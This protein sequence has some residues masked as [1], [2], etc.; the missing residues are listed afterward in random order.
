MNSS[1]FVYIQGYILIKA[2]RA[3]FR[4]GGP[5]TERGSKQARGSGGIPP[6][7]LIT[8]GIF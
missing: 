7:I 8:N 2:D 6:D 4:K 1:V 5:I 3:F